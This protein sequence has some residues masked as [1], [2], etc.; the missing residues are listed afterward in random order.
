M[1]LRVLALLFLP[2]SNPTEGRY[3]AQDSCHGCASN[4]RPELPVGRVLR[5]FLINLHCNRHPIRE[6]FAQ[7]RSAHRH[8]TVLDNK[9]RAEIWSRNAIETVGK[10]DVVPL[11]LS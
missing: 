1:S 8:L 11:S 3:L 6:P 10:H 5:N 9:P 2:L 4:R 7:D